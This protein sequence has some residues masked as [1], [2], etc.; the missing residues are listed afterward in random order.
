M[1]T[2]TPILDINLAM[3]GR[4]E[5][6]SGRREMEKLIILNRTRER[7]CGGLSSGIRSSATNKPKKRKNYRPISIG[8]NEII[9]GE[10]KRGPI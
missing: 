9:A 6:D 5:R 10:H 3:G 7:P 1:A 8:A 2:K 4:L